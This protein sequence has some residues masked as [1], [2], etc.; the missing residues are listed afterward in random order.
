MIERLIVL[1]AL[2][3]FLHYVYLG[4]KEVVDSRLDHTSHAR[5]LVCLID[6]GMSHLRRHLR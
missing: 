1:I 2:L 5:R 3:D 6:V 4:A